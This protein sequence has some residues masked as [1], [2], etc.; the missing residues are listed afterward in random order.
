MN[1]KTWLIDDVLDPKSDFWKYNKYDLDNF[2]TR[3]SPLR[4]KKLFLIQEPDPVLDQFSEFINFFQN[5]SVREAKEYVEFVEDQSTDMLSDHFWKMVDPQDRRELFN[6]DIDKFDK[7]FNSL[8]HSEV[9]YYMTRVATNKRLVP[10][11]KVLAFVKKL[12]TLKSFEKVRNIKSYMLDAG[13]Y[14]TVHMVG[15]QLAISSKD[16]T[17][18]EAVKDMLVDRGN[19]FVEERYKT[20]PKGEKIYTYLFLTK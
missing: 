3:I 18:L 8:H 12:D 6:N 10:P 2:M 4:T 1:T 9:E 7:W 17:K 13:K 5:L 15:E 16:I 20:G 19:I 11:S 14:L